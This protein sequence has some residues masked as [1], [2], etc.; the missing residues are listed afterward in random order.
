MGLDWVLSFTPYGNTWRRYR[1]LMHS[2]THSGAAVNYRPIQLRGARRFVRDL[3]VAEKTRPADKLSEAAMAALPHMIRINFGLT[4]VHMIY[5]IDVRDPAM[6]ERY[7]GV[8]EAVLHALSESAT[9]GRFL[10]DQ[11]PLC[12]SSQLIRN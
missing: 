4:S 3:L 9:P 5:G 6:E 10:V 8:P 7:V 11:I 2:Q 12:K 1:K